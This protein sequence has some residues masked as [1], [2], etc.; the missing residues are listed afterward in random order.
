VLFCAGVIVRSNAFRAEQTQTVSL[1][2]NEFLALNSAVNPNGVLVDWTSKC[3][4]SVP[5]QAKLLVVPEGLAINFLSKHVSP[6]VLHGGAD[7]EKAMLDILNDQSL[8]Y[9]VLI[10]R[11]E[12][13]PRQ[14]GAQGNPGFRLMQWVERNYT[15][16][17][18]WG[19]ACIM[20]RNE[21]HAGRTG[22][23][24]QDGP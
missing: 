14:Y 24:S 7:P 19:G 22:A 2:R 20:R 15:T 11:N 16:N 21:I 12:D 23:F 6:I 5:P 4:S 8:E 3:L 10:T 13:D 1:D 17:A 9:I 18:Y